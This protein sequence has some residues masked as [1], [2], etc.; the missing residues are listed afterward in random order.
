MP[1]YQHGR[2]CRQLVDGPTHKA[3]NRLDLVLPDVPGVVDVRLVAP[4]GKSDHSAIRVDLT[5]EQQVPE[6][7][8]R[9][10]V[11][12]KGRVHWNAVRDDLA[13]TSWGDVYRSPELEVAFA[14]VWKLFVVVF[15][16]K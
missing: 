9:R 5:V 13:S 12:L 6:F 11:Y 14:D 4:I 3:G 7:S 1:A 8:V 16:Q 10:E 15:Q 2:G